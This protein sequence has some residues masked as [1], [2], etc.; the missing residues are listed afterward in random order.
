MQQNAYIY[1]NYSHL[2]PPKKNSSNLLHINNYLVIE[3]EE[4]LCW[5][6][7]SNYNFE[8]RFTVTTPTATTTPT[9]ILHKF[10]L[11]LFSHCGLFSNQRWKHIIYFSFSL[12]LFTRFDFSRFFLEWILIIEG[13]AFGNGKWQIRYYKWK[14]NM[15][16]GRILWVVSSIRRRKAQIKLTLA[17]NLKSKCVFGKKS[18]LMKKINGPV[19]FELQIYFRVSKLTDSNMYHVCNICLDN[20]NMIKWQ[21]GSCYTCFILNW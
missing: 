3:F 8:K 20:G 14:E 5:R 17:H 7:P 10:F 11:V 4:H 6:S 15:W 21:R 1:L 19:I 16:F 18:N 9:R 12:R 2:Y 13:A